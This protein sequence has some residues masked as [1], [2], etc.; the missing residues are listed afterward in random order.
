VE[1]AP[2]AKILTPAETMTPATMN[3]QAMA[4]GI[5]EI[6]GEVRFVVAR[7]RAD[8]ARFRCMH[9]ELARNGPPQSGLT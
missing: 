3:H 2:V 8:T 6:M 4:G 7:Y 9:L 1:Q 5:Q